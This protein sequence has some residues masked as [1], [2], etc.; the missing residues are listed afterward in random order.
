MD[1]ASE[2]RAAL[3]WAF[4]CVELLDQS[5]GGRASAH[6]KKLLRLLTP[7][8][9]YSIAKKAMWAASEGLEVLG[10]NGYIEDWP[11]ARVLRDVQVLPIWE[12]STNVLVL[13]AFRAIRKESVH[14]AL[15]GEL[16]SL[17][18]DAPAALQA[19]VGPQVD[20]LG[21]ALLELNADPRAESR[22]RDWTDRAA[23]LWQVAILGSKGAGHGTPGD[24]RAA[25][26]VFARNLPQGLLRTDRA[27]PEEVRLVALS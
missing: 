5:D 17:L 8:V 4:R 6:E 23:L 9:K 11:M 25:E 24:L 26:R 20:A 21:Q 22:L 7:L 15:F 14:E 2:Q 27:T 12:G 18:S 3:A 1:L 10:G 13:D 19:K 16:E